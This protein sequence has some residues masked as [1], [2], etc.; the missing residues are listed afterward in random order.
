MAKKELE[1]NEYLL[2]LR[3]WLSTLN[4]DFISHLEIS[5]RQAL[6]VKA[7]E[8]SVEILEKRVRLLEAKK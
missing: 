5:K 1:L 2:K 7:L 6:K 3:D 8:E 4:D